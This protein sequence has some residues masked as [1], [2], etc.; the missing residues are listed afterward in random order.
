MPSE[1]QRWFKHVQYRLY[2]TF[3]L[4]SM[5]Q[6]V[7]GLASKNTGKQF[8]NLYSKKYAST[9]E[10]CRS[11]SSKKFSVEEKYHTQQGAQ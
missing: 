1:R 8:L 10:P 11:N 5:G 7:M 4:L 2:T 9:Q 3:I 6:K